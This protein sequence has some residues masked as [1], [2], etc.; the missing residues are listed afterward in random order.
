[1]TNALDRL[2]AELEKRHEALIAE[3][4]KLMKKGTES[5]EFLAT[6]IT[7][8]LTLR[9]EYDWISKRINQIKAAE[10]RRAR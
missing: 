10:R 9:R 5:E 1:M 7:A 8:N 4:E 6:A 3:G 2:E